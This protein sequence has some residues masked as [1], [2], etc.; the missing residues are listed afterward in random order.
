MGED[1]RRRVSRSGPVARLPPR[2]A[3]WSVVARH[4]KPR[5]RRDT[6]G[7]QAPNGGDLFSIRSI[8]T[9]GRSHRICV[10]RGTETTSSRA[11][12]TASTRR[13]RPIGQGL[14]E[15]PGCLK[16]LDR[17]QDW[18]VPILLM[19]D[20]HPDATNNSSRPKTLIGLPPALI[21]RA[22]ARISFSC[23]PFRGAANR[24]TYSRNST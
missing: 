16:Y 20:S 14:S 24:P 19:R 11:R 10:A 3:R 23:V 8:L 17:D 13:P 15:H 5:V 7:T 18:V 2:D 6:G 9:R 22:H 4:Q 12:T 1:I 21:L